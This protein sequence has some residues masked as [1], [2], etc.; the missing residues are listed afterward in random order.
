MAAFAAGI[1]AAAAVEFSQNMSFLI[2]AKQR[3]ADQLVSYTL[4]F[5]ALGQ[6]H[7]VER[8]D[9]VT[10]A[11]FREFVSEFEADVL[12]TGLVEPPL[13]V[14]LEAWRKYERGMG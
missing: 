2:A 3:R 13:V 9:L 11:R 10:E 7:L 6:R 5:K 1:P 4:V 14:D 12:A 8:E